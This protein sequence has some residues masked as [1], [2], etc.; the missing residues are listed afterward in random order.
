MLLSLVSINVVSDYDLQGLVLLS[1][2]VNALLFGLIS[3]ASMLLL[4]CVLSLALDTNMY[5][6]GLQFACMVAVLTEQN[7]QG[8]ILRAC[9]LPWPPSSVR[10][11]RLGL[12][13]AF[14]ALISSV[15]S[16]PSNSLAGETF[17]EQS[18]AIAGYNAQLVRGCARVVQWLCLRGRSQAFLN[19]GA[20]L[21]E[22]LV[23]LVNDAYRLH[24]PITRVKMMRLPMQRAHIQV[25]V[26]KRCWRAYRSW[27]MRHV[28]AHRTLI[29][30]R[31]LEMMFL[32]AVNHGMLH[33]SSRMWWL[34]FAVILRFGY[35][36]VLR[37][38]RAV[39]LRV[40]DVLFTENAGLDGTLQSCAVLAL[41]SPKTKLLWVV[42]NSV[43]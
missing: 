26:L 32:D 19:S 5:M 14:L 11:S 30:E 31:M 4:A 42:I 41:P 35:V 2:H 23:H 25:G 9:A 7:V 24:W 21:V 17:L 16:V 33:S 3:L 34:C 12:L 8:H 39:S 28:R 40:R 43:F 18:H 37:P 29:P 10:M 27:D 6:H 22:E 38:I 20:I 15:C 36:A 13:L 1:S